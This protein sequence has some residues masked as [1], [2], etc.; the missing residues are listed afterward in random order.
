MVIDTVYGP[1]P[2]FVSAATMQ[3]YAVKGIKPPKVK[4]V[5]DDV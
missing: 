5:S 3:A 2:M 1:V 4:V